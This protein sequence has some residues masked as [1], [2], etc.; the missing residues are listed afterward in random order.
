MLS[1]H[2]ITELECLRANLIYLITDDRILYGPS[3][4]FIGVGSWL[5]LGQEVLRK[6]R[7]V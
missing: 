3:V 6:N 5:F 7:I 1:G 4:E 2:S